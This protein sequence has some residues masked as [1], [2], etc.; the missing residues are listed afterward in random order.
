LILMAVMEQE[1]SSDDGID[2]HLIDR[3]IDLD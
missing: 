2:D 1:N 3:L